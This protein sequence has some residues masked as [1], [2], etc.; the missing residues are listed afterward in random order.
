ML[1]VPD[2]TENPGTDIC[3]FVRALP[4][5]SAPT[6]FYYSVSPLQSFLC[7]ALMPTL[8]SPSLQDLAHAPPCSSLFYFSWII[9]ICYFSS[10]LFKI[11]PLPETFPD[12]FSFHGCPPVL[13]THLRETPLYLFRTFL[14]SSLFPEHVT[15]SS[16]FAPAGWERCFFPCVSMHPAQCLAQ[17]THRSCF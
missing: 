11:P 1:L 4:Q 2:H 14:F 13:C 7:P 16:W 15:H 12:V 9:I 10:D 5:L 3:P 8:P 6:T 17:G